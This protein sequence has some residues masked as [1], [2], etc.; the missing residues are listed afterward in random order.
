MTT[1][2][3]VIVV[4]LLLAAAAAYF[5][6]QRR[7]KERAQLRERFG[8][9]YDRTVDETG[10]RRSA[11]HRLSDAAARRDKAE[12]RDLTP[13]ERERF[14]E[15]WTQAQAD[16][17]DDPAGAASSAD[18]LVGQVMRERGYP[19]DDVD[20]RGDLVAADHA[21]L[22][23]HYRSAHAIGGRAHE[24]STEE[25]RQAFVHY[26]ALFTE[27]LGEPDG[28]HAVA[29]PGAAAAATHTVGT[30]DDSRTD[31]AAAPTR[32]RATADGTSRR[33]DPTGQR[34][35]DLTEGEQS[36]TAPGREKPTA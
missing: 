2:I 30:A 28:R 32:G 8:P 3:V 5:Y 10:N 25:L 24:A 26:R 9:E 1:A 11:E 22:A 7:K 19:L 6:V 23:H 13:A 17:V 21:E 18:S 12:V 14:T 27:L 29:G 31:D 35:L 4:V 33:T 15:R 16:F 36:R 34:Q 20:D